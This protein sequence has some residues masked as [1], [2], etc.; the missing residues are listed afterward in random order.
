ME[1]YDKSKDKQ[2]SIDE[3]APL[4]TQQVYRHHGTE[5]EDLDRMR[6]ELEDRFQRFR[7]LFELY[8]QS[9]DSLLD[10][11]ELLRFALPSPEAEV[12]FKTEDFGRKVNEARALSVDH[13]EDGFPR[14]FTKD[15]MANQVLYHKIG[16]DF[17]YILR[18]PEGTHDEL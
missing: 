7:L 16:G 11:L 12:E 9:K 17:F 1:L 8:D 6:Q 15:S 2:L 5:K 14:D 10:N 3:M 18:K 13:W 4:F